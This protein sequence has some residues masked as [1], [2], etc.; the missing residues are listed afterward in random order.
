MGK[1][2]VDETVHLAILELWKCHYSVTEVTKIM[3]LSK[4][5]ISSMFRGFKIA[6]LQQYDRISLSQV[7]TVKEDI[8]KCQNR[9]SNQ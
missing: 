9:L 2:K 4:P 1:R 7:T 6:G 5:V 3:N 8:L